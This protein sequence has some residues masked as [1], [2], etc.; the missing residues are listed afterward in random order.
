MPPK[1]IYPN[2][3][4]GDFPLHKVPACIACNNAGSKDDEEFKIVVGMATGEFRGDGS[5]VIE[6]IARTLKVNKK[7]AKKIFK[8]SQRVYADRGRGILE[9]LIAVTFGEGG[10]QRV[11]A[12]IVRGLYW[13]ETGNIYSQES[14]I[15]VVTPEYLDY[16]TRAAIKHALSLMRPKYLN[17]DT[18]KYT[19]YIEKD[20][21]G[22]WAV[23]FF[24]KLIAFAIATA[25]KNIIKSPENSSQ[26][27]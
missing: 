4:N 5:D 12:R 6:S 17:G 18:V 24:G 15:T 2:R 25:D 14:Y 10:Y 1:N 3:K 8:N 20:G 22:F 7:M 27:I 11:V 21:S 19:C 9:P 16:K 13:R 23:Q 26:E